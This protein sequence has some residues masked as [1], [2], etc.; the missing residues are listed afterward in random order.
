MDASKRQR[1]KKW[2]KETKFTPNKRTNTVAIWCRYM[3]FKEQQWLS[4]IQMK[5]LNRERQKKK[6]MIEPREEKQTY[7]QSHKYNTNTQYNVLFSVILKE[8]KFHDVADTHPEVRR[9]RER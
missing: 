7:E 1:E 4:R 8:L 5:S 6:T 2:K 3:H 9:E